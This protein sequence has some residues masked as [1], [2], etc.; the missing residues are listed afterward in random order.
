MQK[1]A[2]DIYIE[3][4]FA[5]VTVGAI[6]TPDGL[7][8]IDTPTHPADARRW[9]LKLIQLSNAPIRYVV[10]LDHHRDR[11]LGNQWF[12]APVIAHE[13]ASERL[14]Q[15]PEL[16]K[17]GPSEAGADSD[18][19]ADLAGVRLVAPTL[20]FSDRIEL[21]LGG[22]ELHLVRR[23]GSG[24]GAIWAELPAE[25]IVFTGDALTVGVPPPMVEAD[26]DAW[27]E[28]LATLRKARFP[29]K[30]IVPGRG[31]PTTRDGVKAMQ[32]FLRKVKRR[33]HSLVHTHKPRAEAA[34]LADELIDDFKVPAALR[35]HYVRRLRAGLESLYDQQA[36]LPP[37]RA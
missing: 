35:E 10:N 37:E 1:L 27:I 23:P 29:A 5:G 21:I 14:R 24:P 11:V 4:G 9:Q 6:V 28:T 34:R 17:G 18:L 25:Q 16:F 31:A 13:A 36:A 8:C 15:M 33:V 22:H 26:L 3:S 2:K 7:I 20:T 12:D 19:A 30:I 32:E